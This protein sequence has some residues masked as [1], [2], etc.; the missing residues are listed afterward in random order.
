[1]H[2]K[3]KI[4]K[5]YME[6]F[7]VEI[8]E[9]VLDDLKFRLGNIRWPP[10]FANEDWSY[11]TNLNE[12]KVLCSYWQNDFDW[13]VQ[14]EKINQYE[15]FKVDIEGI[16]IHFLHARGK[17]P[18]PKPLI[19]SHG[20]PWTFWDFNKLI[21]PLTDPVSFGGAAEDAFD[22]V[23]PSLPGFGFS[24]PLSKAGVNAW[25]TADLWDHLMRDVLGYNRYY[26]QG[27][28]WGAILTAQLGHKYAEHL[29]G[30]HLNLTF[31]LGFPHESFP[32]LETYASEESHWFER[33]AKF[34][35][36]DSG[37]SSIQGSRP[38]TLSY[39]M[40]DSPAALAAWILEK[41]RSWSDS[42]GDVYSRFSADDLCTTFTIYWVTQTFFTSARYYYEFFADPWKPT[43]S[44][45]PVVKAPT[46]VAV[47]PEEL[48]MVSKQWATEYY[49]LKR[50]MPMPHG[51]HFAPMEEPELLV[52]EIRSAFRGSS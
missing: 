33:T 46:S 52:D 39:G 2:A 12:L 41:R 51:G 50:W 24:S 28:D 47:F 23:V 45:R 31:P 17:G 25:V 29:Y 21:D 49:N 16:P 4:R 48:F 26:A 20:W 27:G 11:G 18:Q 15:N 7:T 43:H 5:K 34:F 42:K 35:A 30:I 44:E 3:I 37:Y 1:M 40:H 32:G 36:E 8:P 9:N 38:Q 22:V 19:L 6:T 14:E 10:D 13:R